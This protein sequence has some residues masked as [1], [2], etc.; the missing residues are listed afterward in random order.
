MHA[1]ARME[2]KG[3]GYGGA[4]EASL[5]GLQRAQGGVQPCQPSPVWS[6]DVRRACSPTWGPDSL[7]R[8]WA[9]LAATCFKLVL[10]TNS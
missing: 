3:L 1:H 9:Q 8:I 2:I 5:T 6:C 10:P 7:G 4:H